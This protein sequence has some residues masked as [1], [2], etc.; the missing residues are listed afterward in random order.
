MS[1]CR[2]ILLIIVRGP[3]QA[4]CLSAANETDSCAKLRVDY[5]LGSI[6]NEIKF[7]SFIINSPPL[8]VSII[9]HSRSLLK[10]ECHLLAHKTCFNMEWAG[11]KRKQKTKP[12]ADG[13]QKALG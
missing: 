10:L 6:I 9:V 4:R 2:S 1:T 3:L 13:V 7:L 11:K 5:Y 12:N 8:F